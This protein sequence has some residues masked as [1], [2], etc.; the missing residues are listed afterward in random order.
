MLVHD[1]H[2]GFARKYVVTSRLREY[3]MRSAA[4]EERVGQIRR[5][6]IRKE[7]F[8]LPEEKS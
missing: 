8:W 7:P 6:F 1:R 2:L 4:E 5:R 3:N